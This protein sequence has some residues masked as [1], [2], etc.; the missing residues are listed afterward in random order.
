VSGHTLKHLAAGLG[1]IPLVVWLA[2]RDMV[3]GEADRLSKRAG[4]GVQ[5]VA[6]RRM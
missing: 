5:A 6:S 3:R 2:R 4:A 1:F